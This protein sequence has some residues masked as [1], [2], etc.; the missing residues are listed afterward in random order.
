METTPFV[1]LNLHPKTAKE[2]FQGL[3]QMITISALH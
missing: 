3:I 2:T 1:K